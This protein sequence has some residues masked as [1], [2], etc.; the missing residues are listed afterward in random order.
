[1]IQSK[2]PLY[3]ITTAYK[4]KQ[5]IR[6]YLE[7]LY[8]LINEVDNICIYIG[9]DGCKETLEEIVRI[10]ENESYLSNDLHFKFY[11]SE[12]NVG[13]Y[14]MKNSLLKEIENGDS[15]IHFF[16]IDDI[17][18]P[19]YIEE[20]FKKCLQLKS[21]LTDNFILRAMHFPLDNDI[22]DYIFK[23]KNN[24]RLND[25]FA[26]QLIKNGN[27]LEAL[28]C[29]VI[30]CI[31]SK[32]ISNK[33]SILI[34]KYQSLKFDLIQRFKT[35]NRMDLLKIC[36]NNLNYKY[37]SLDTYKIIS[38]IIKLYYL[39][40]FDLNSIL[41]N[42]YLPVGSYGVFFCTYNCIQRLGFFNKYRVDQDN[43]IMKRA[44]T[45]GINII[46]DES[47]PFFIR[48]I[49]TTSLTRNHDTGYS[50]PYRLRIRSINDKLIAKNILTARGIWQP[51][52]RI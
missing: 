35:Y 1:M 2:T 25:T 33:F 19:G 51:L 8:N 38:E 45:L 18:L 22:I 43:D 52:T 16:D 37:T 13:T 49:S 14:V 27:F 31:N 41:Q 46:T 39:K 9:I 44:K 20:N 28:V 10:K 11:F 7:T 50:S 47:L 21:K 23:E 24:D 36:L 30:M 17:M 29:I 48:R 5:Y 15:I 6:P 40:E 12:K 32:K 34:E 42:K 26:E 4:A 3:I